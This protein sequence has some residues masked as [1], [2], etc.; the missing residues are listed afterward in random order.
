MKSQM[1]LRVSNSGRMS[2]SGTK[3]EQMRKYVASA[4]GIVHVTWM[5]W[6][7]ALSNWSRDRAGCWE[8][9]GQHI[10]IL[11]QRGYNAH[12]NV[13]VRHG[14]GGMQ[15]KRNRGGCANMDNQEHQ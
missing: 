6:K 15:E 4:I 5:A 10:S 1:R 14:G 2:K 11:Q 8:D 12:M 13:C 7:Q 9:G 3:E